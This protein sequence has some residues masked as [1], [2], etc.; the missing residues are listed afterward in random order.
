MSPNESPH[1]SSHGP[2]RIHTTAPTPIQELPEPTYPVYGSDDNH[3]EEDN[4]ASHDGHEQLSPWN[5][6]RRHHNHDDEPESPGGGKLAHNFADANKEDM[7]KDKGGSQGIAGRRPSSAVSQRHMSGDTEVEG[8]AKH[9]ATIKDSA[10]DLENENLDPIIS[11]SEDRE[12]DNRLDDELAVLEMERKVSQ[13]QNADSDE[14]S[15]R[16]TSHSR[17]GGEPVDEFEEATNPLHEQQAAKIRTVDNPTTRLAKFVTK[18]HASHFLVRYFVYIIPVV[19]ILVIPLVIAVK[20]APGSSLG[21]VKLDWFFVWLIIIW[22]T[23]WLARILAKCLPWCVG[24]ISSIF[25]S[26]TKKWSG[27]G[28][29]MELPVTFFLWMLSVE[30]SFLPTMKGHHRGGKQT[31]QW[32]HV[33][34]KIIIALLVASAFLMAEKLL[35]QLIATRFHMRTYADRIEI[36]R[37]QIGALTKLYTYSKE[38]IGLS[39]KTFEETNEDEKDDQRRGFAKPMQYAGRASGFAKKALN[40]VGDV[41]GAVAGDFTGKAMQRSSNPRQVVLALLRTNSGSQVL[42]RRLYRT[43]VAPD[44]DVISP[45]DLRKGLDTSEEAEAVFTFFDRDMNG[46]ISMEELEH[47]CVEIGRERK[48]ITASLKDIDSVVRRLDA[49]FLFIVLI[50]SLVVLISIISTSAAGVLVSVG[51]VLLALSWLFS[52]TTQELLQSIIF[53]FVKHPF[54][55]GDRVTIYGTTGAKGTGD[56]YFVK[57]ISLLYTEFKKMEGHV[58]QAPNSYLNTLFILNQRRS[59]GLSE[60]VPI[61][62]RFGTSLEQIEMLRNRLLEF[63]RSEKRDYQ[64]NVLTELREVTE[65]YSITLNVVFFYR[66]SW[67]NELLRLQ[68]RNK[69]F[70]H[71][72]I[73]LLEVG[74]DGPRLNMPGA[75][76]D[77]AWHSYTI[78]TQ[79]PSGSPSPPQYTPNARPYKRESEAQEPSP[80][81]PLDGGGTSSSVQRQSSIL[82]RPSRADT[83]SS[84]RI[85][86][87]RKHVD[88]SL[89]VPS[90]PGDD[91]DPSDVHEDRRRDRFDEAI[92]QM[93]Q[94]EMEKQEQEK[95]EQK[96][97]EEREKR[98]KEE[99]E[100]AGRRRSSAAG[101]GSRRSLSFASFSRP[102]RDSTDSQSARRPSNTA[103]SKQSAPSGRSKSILSRITP[104]VSLSRRSGDSQEQQ[105]PGSVSERDL[106]SGQA[107][108]AAAMSSRDKARKVYGA[109]KNRADQGDEEKKAELEKADQEQEGEG[110]GGGDTGDQHGEAESVE[111]KQRSVFHYPQHLPYS[112]HMFHPRSPHHGEHLSPTDVSPREDPRTHRHLSPHPHPPSNLQHSTLAEPDEDEEGEDPSGQKRSSRQESI[113]SGA[114]ATSGQGQPHHPGGEHHHH[115]GH[116]GDDAKEQAEVNQGK[117]EA[118]HEGGRENANAT[119][120]EAQAQAH[121]TAGTAGDAADANARAAQGQAHPQHGAGGQQQA[122]VP[123]GPAPA[124]TATLTGQQGG[125]YEGSISHAPGGAHGA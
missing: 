75:R 21:R 35:I 78:P 18:V 76:V 25:T 19:C 16:S 7:N 29:N 110:E 84:T 119:S 72:M 117:A 50:F 121:H 100:N 6:S 39:D 2:P 44:N 32:E 96:E 37:F 125:H 83:M 8:N 3:N 26:N 51:S 80:Q 70:C 91:Y 59:G 122:Q 92:R 14:G 104:S 114:Q 41:A 36:N 33:V 13:H 67:Q 88:F 71:L 97:A 116:G 47:C 101:S 81:T 54:D 108:T 69:F 89:G 22:L 82:R 102:S 86:Q 120:D 64:P 15:H 48:S 66:S 46:D 77:L 124:R 85:G 99:Q 65:N 74:I 109:V 56:D 112:P 42:A 34:N 43:F 107:R 49:I 58:V 57:E 61:I 123:H 9:S 10:V 23:L 12:H 1:E 31:D 111:E 63:V 103:D 106:E 40:K 115:G 28:K 105:T 93:N 53:V 98:E 118:R 27:I 94:K 4:S 79:S 38:N 30:I 73:S 62:I 24:M 113:G 60:A 68:R 95:R 20:A 17:R 87:G 90:L 45:D 5:Q 52:A 55:V 11:Q